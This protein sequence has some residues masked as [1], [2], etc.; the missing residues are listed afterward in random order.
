VK[1]AEDGDLIEV[2]LALIAPGNQHFIVLLVPLAL[3]PCR[4]AN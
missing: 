3:L 4:I 2:G 1:E